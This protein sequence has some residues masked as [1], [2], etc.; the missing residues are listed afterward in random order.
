MADGASCVESVSLRIE[1]D[2]TPPGSP[3]PEPQLLP[4]FYRM[5]RELSLE[6]F[7]AVLFDVD[8]TLV[9][10]LQMLTHGLADTLERF[11]DSKPSSETIV[12]LMG[13]PLKE[14]LSRYGSDASADRLDEMAQFAMERNLHYA[15]MADDHLAAIETV[16]LCKNSGMKTGL[17][18]SKNAQETNIFLQTFVAKDCIDAVVCAS[19]V[20]HHKPH[21]ESVLVA[22]ERL[23][24]QP[25]KAVM[26]GDSIYDIQCA[27]RAGTSTVA[28]AY[29]SATAHAL[30]AQNPDVLIHTPEGLLEWARANLRQP[31]CSERN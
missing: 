20:I 29:G 2:Y 18:T 22:C 14:Q 1:P 15:H 31:T 10:S 13:L 24:V 25:A 11:T 21:P 23:G 12:G 17:V 27:Q 7:E 30:Q 3:P 16:R 5:V 26:V 8:G 9:D 19:D 6:S 4:Y 28:V